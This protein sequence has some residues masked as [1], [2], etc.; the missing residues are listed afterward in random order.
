MKYSVNPFK[1][2]CNPSNM[3]LYSLE[4]E[5]YSLEY[6]LW[7]IKLHLWCIPLCAPIMHSLMHRCIPLCTGGPTRRGRR[8]LIIRWSSGEHRNNLESHQQCIWIGPW[9]ENLHG[10]TWSPC[11]RNPSPPWRAPGSSPRSSAPSFRRAPSRFARH[12]PLGR[13]WK[14]MCLLNHFI[15]QGECSV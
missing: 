15:L 1:I 13:K 7:Y 4:Y 10:G 9:T 5:L 14:L 11:S 3:H 2:Q 8:N 6:E 12:P